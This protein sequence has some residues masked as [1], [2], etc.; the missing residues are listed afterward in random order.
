[1]I[2]PHRLK[3]KL[4]A[5][6]PAIG[7]IVNFNSPWF[8]DICGLMG[9]DF[10]LVDCEHGPMTPESAEGM[11]RAAEA[12]G[13]S[14]IVR[15]AANVPHEILRYLDVG[16]VGIKVPHIETGAEA[17][18]AADA[19]RY[20]PRG[21]RGLAAITRAAAYGIDA[22][23]TKYV[24]TANREVVLLAMVETARGVENIDAI[25]ATE[26]VDLIALGP[27]DLSVSMGHG[28][29][30]SHPDVVAAMQHVVARAKA[31]GKW[32]SLPA[33]DPASAAQCIADGAN[34]IFVGPAPWLAQVGRQFIADAIRT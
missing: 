15:V 5:G 16:A 26:G 31:H 29:V 18:A 25:A 8:V 6:K 23:L 22:P 30:R 13:I 10:V 27:G 11:I 12:A 21:R 32:C 7:P 9:F 1:M 19:V 24:E 4:T 20:P 3:Q 33:N 2:G 34:M 14:P 28:G 17:R